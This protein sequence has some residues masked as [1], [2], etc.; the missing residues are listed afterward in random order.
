[1]SGAGWIMFLF[2]WALIIGLSGFCMNRVLRLQQTQAEHIRPIHEID[3]GDLGAY[4]K[5]K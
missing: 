3:T 5:E 1:M 4:K 2:S